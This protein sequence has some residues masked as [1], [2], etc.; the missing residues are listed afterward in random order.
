MLHV[1]FIQ[2]K[3]EFVQ[4]TMQVASKKKNVADDAG[5]ILQAKLKQLASSS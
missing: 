4:L 5:V 1:T 3:V 2:K